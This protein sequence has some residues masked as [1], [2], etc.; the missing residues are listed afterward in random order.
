MG[1]TDEPEGRPDITAL[2]DDLEASTAPLTLV[3]GTREQSVV[4]VADVAELARRRPDATVV[5]VDAGHSVQG[6]APLELARI[7][8]QANTD[9]AITEGA[10][11]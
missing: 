4:D 11:P 6:D 9:H 3:R 2:W 10:A 7:I 1:D 5:E 8:D